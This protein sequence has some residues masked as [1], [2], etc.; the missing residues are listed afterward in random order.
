MYKYEQQRI[1]NG[2]KA[3]R[4]KIYG[5]EQFVSGGININGE[6][7]RSRTYDPVISGQNEALGYQNVY[8]GGM[9]FRTK[10]TEG[11]VRNLY[12]EDDL[13]DNSSS[14]FDTEVFSGGE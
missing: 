4:T 10:I 8:N 2:E 1:E 3:E 14:A 5:G 12:V 9:V 7:V 11:G 13:K 6:L